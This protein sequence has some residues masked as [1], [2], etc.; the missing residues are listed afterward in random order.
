MGGLL[1]PV[2]ELL[3]HRER[4]LLLDEVREAGEASIAC[5]VV[6]R[7]ASPFVEN[8]RVN[9]IV[10]IEYMAQCVG[11]WVGLQDR[12]N[13]QPIRIGYLVGSREVTFAVDDFVV[14]DDLRVEASRLWGD[15]S[16]GHF[17]CRVERGGATVAEGVLNVY[18]G[19]SGGGT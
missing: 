19:A 13:G 10:A 14:G 12:R 6:L 1:P 4:M 8:G 2:E 17:A 7:E 11:A 5:G 16:L 15:D 9:A 3:P 18:R